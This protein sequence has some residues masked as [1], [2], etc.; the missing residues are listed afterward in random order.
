MP[1]I[2]A[3]FNPLYILCDL[4]FMVKL[5]AVGALEFCCAGTACS[6]LVDSTIYFSNISLACEGRF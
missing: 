5:C 6:L 2:K 3:V 4:C 1:M